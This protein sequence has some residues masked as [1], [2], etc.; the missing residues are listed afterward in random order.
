VGPVGLGRCS[1]APLEFWIS[2]LLGFLGCWWQGQPGPAG[3]GQGAA[4]GHLPQHVRGGVLVHHQ[5]Q[6][7]GAGV[8]LAVEQARV[9]AAGQLHGQLSSHSPDHLRGRLADAVVP[10]ALRFQVPGGCVGCGAWGG[11]W[12]VGGG[13]RHGPAAGLTCHGGLLQPGTMPEAGRAGPGSVLGDGRRPEVGSRPTDSAG[14]THST[15][16]TAQGLPKPQGPALGSAAQAA[17]PALPHRGG[18]LHVTRQPMLAQHL[19][20]QRLGKHRAARVALTDQQ[21]ARLRRPG[22]WSGFCFREGGGRCSCRRGA[23]RRVVALA[24]RV[25]CSGAAQPFWR[26]R[27]GGGACLGALRWRRRRLLLWLPERALDHQAAHVDVGLRL[28][29]AQRYTA[30]AAR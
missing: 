29:L 27:P 26:S 2:G 16:L 17:S 10:G 4:A 9:V 5:H 24:R 14:C 20:E 7:R 13:G 23:G 3:A 25:G 28:H 15:L 19:A 12:G 6:V 30:A 18:D 11:G 8:P 22:A 21:D 1:R